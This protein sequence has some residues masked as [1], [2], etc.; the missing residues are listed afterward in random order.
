MCVTTWKFW[1]FCGLRIQHWAMG[2]WD[3]PASPVKKHLSTLYLE[4]PYAVEYA[5]T[6]FIKNTHTRGVWHISKHLHPL[7]STINLQN[8]RVFMCVN[9]WVEKI[10]T[11]YRLISP[12]LQKSISFIIV[13][14]GSAHT[15]WLRLCGASGVCFRRQLILVKW[16]DTSS[17]CCT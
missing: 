16:Y 14:P 7:F 3:W 17:V 15:T 5:W 12:A 13:T 6:V 9:F 8:R 1:H 10:F 11:Y 4:I 2:L